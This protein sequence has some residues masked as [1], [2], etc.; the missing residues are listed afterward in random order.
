VAD[1]EDDGIDSSVGIRKQL[2]EVLGAPYFK[3]EGLS[4]VP[5]ADGGDDLLVFGVREIGRSYAD[6][7]YAVCLV[8][9]PYHMEGDD[10][11]PTGAFRV[12]YDFDATGWPGLRHVVG[13]SSL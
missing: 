9:A 12:L 5:A 2:G 7:R 11:V 6:F 3:I 10:L 1:T 13:V 4:C 8:G